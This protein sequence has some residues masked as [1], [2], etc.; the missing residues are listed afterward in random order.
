MKGGISVTVSMYGRMQGEAGTVSCHFGSVVVE[1]VVR[2]HFSVV[3]VSP[4]ARTQSAVEFRVSE[5]SSGAFLTGVSSFEYLEELQIVNVRPS[6]GTVGQGTSVSVTLSR[7]LS[8]AEGLQ[9]RFG[10][11]IVTGGSVRMTT[12]SQLT[13]LAPVSL[14]AEGGDCGCEHKRRRGVHYQ[15]GRFCI[16]GG[17]NP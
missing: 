10:N 15:R 11:K 8:D 4:K 3:C 6:I 7:G 13:C 17:S 2:G 9:C 12:S 1:G 5:G 14:V 16:R